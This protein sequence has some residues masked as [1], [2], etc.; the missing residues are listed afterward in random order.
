MPVDDRAVA[1]SA[2]IAGPDESHVWVATDTGMILKL[3]AQ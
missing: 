1:H 2:I 3:I